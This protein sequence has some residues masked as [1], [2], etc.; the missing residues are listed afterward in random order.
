MCVG[1]CALERPPVRKKTNHRSIHKEA[2]THQDGGAGVG[3]RVA[4]GLGHRHAHA[5]ERLGGDVLAGVCGVMQL[6]YECGFGCKWIRGENQLVMRFVHE[7]AP[8]STRTGRGAWRRA[9]RPRGS[10]ARTPRSARAVWLKYVVVLV[11]VDW[12]IG[13]CA[14]LLLPDPPYI[15]THTITPHP[16]PTQTQTNPPTTSAAR[17]AVPAK[18][19]SSHS[20]S[21]VSTAARRGFTWR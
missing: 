17:R 8:N 20:R 16:N 18:S 5:P 6:V 3:G 11:C 15:Y 1:T 7:L 21:R 14:S 10:A 4:Q 12:I 19:S 2:I 9:C 13:R